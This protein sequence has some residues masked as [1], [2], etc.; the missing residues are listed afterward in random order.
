MI[1][2]LYTKH[3]YNSTDLFV[4][5]QI[6]TCLMRMSNYQAATYGAENYNG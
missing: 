6:R 2:L 3:T 4:K 5:I 1:Q